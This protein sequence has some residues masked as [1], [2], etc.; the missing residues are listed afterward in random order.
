MRKQ[1]LTGF[2]PPIVAKV[3]GGTSSAEETNAAVTL[4]GTTQATAVQLP[5][6]TNT[7]TGASNTGG[8]LPKNASAND[9][10]FVANSGGNTIKIYP[11]T[12]AG[13]INGGSAGAAVT[14]ATLKAADFRCIDGADNWY[15]VVTG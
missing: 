11:Q 6:D 3:L 7:V 2:F 5:Y 1:S 12:A 9:T 13:T 8:L 14:L 4:L 15:Y 10:C